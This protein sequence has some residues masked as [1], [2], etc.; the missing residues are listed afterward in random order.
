M[1]AIPLMAEAALTRSTG[2]MV[3]TFLLMAPGMI[4]WI[5]APGTIF[6]PI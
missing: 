3:P 1:V 6:I 4:G 5:L 2:A